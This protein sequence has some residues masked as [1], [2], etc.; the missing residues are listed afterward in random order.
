MSVTLLIVPAHMPIQ[1]FAVNILKPFLITSADTAPLTLHIYSDIYILEKMKQRNGF[2]KCQ[3]MARDHKAGVRKQ[4]LFLFLSTQMLTWFHFIIRLYYRFETKFDLI[5]ACKNKNG[6][7]FA[8]VHMAFNSFL[9]IAFWWL[10][11]IFS[12]L[13][14]H[15]STEMCKRYVL[16]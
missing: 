8:N 4:N 9:K 7:L 5:T 10:K 16:N 6:K 12:F 2:I 1:M 13:K 3:H 15:F 14:S 11:L